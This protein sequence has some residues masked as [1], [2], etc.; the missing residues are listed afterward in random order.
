[1]HA[2]HLD[3]RALTGSPSSDE[4]GLN[5]RESM[6]KNY[7]LGLHRSATSLGLDVKTVPAILHRQRGDPGEKRVR[8]CDFLGDSTI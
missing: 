8:D 3:K 1:M 2:T 4:S 6:A 5:D 7:W